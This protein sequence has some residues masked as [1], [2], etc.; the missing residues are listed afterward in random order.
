MFI[1]FF[2]LFYS[3]VDAIWGICSPTFQPR[4]WAVQLCCQD[5]LSKVRQR[6]CWFFSNIYSYIYWQNK[7]PLLQQFGYTPIKFWPSAVAFNTRGSVNKWYDLC[8]FSLYFCIEIQIK[9]CSQLWL[10]YIDSIKKTDAR[11]CNGFCTSVLIGIVYYRT[12]WRVGQML[13]SVQI[14]LPHDT[15]IPKG[16][17]VCY[18]MGVC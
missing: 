7:L 16:I 18:A 11:Q 3:L 2:L 12:P 1:F 13:H 6:L 17:Y 5:M 10:F 4:T 14:C 8:E 9:K 15:T